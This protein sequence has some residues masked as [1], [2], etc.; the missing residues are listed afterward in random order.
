MKKYWV[1]SFIAL[2]IA[3][4]AYADNGTRTIYFCN[5][6]VDSSSANNTTENPDGS[7]SYTIESHVIAIF[8]GGG[9]P[10]EISLDGVNDLTLAKSPDDLLGKP[11]P[12]YMGYTMDT[13]SGEA[14]EWGADVFF[15]D[16]F[17]GPHGQDQGRM[18]IRHGQ[19]EGAPLD[20]TFYCQLN[21]GSVWPRH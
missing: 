16:K 7:Q 1:G 15:E 4:T 21:E 10:T 8:E 13:D 6:L 5:Q 20:T 9:L 17:L 14:D 11:I 19:E 12:G 18:I 3:I 2:A